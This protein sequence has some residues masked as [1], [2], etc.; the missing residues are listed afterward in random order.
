MPVIDVLPKNL[1]DAHFDKGSAVAN[2]ITI[3]NA[4]DWT[5]GI[6]ARIVTGS[7]GHIYLL[8]NGGDPLVDPVGDTGT[9]WIKS[10]AVS[11][12]DPHTIPEDKLFEMTN[13]SVANGAAG[14]FLEDDILNGLGV[15]PAFN[16]GRYL[17]FYFDK[18]VV[19]KAKCHL[20]NIVATDLDGNVVVPQ[21]IF[22]D[23]VDKTADFAAG[24]MV[25][26]KFVRV[27]F[28]DRITLAKLEWETPL[29]ESPYPWVISIG[30]DNAKSKNNFALIGDQRCGV[31]FSDGKAH[32]FE[33]T[34]LNREERSEPNLVAKIVTNNM[35]THQ[36]LPSRYIETSTM[37]GFKDTNVIEAGFTGSVNAALGYW[38]NNSAVGSEFTLK[39]IT[40]GAGSDL[41][42][43][44]IDVEL[45]PTELG[46]INTVLELWVMPVNGVL[47]PFVLV[48]LMNDDEHIDQKIGT[49][50]IYSFG[51]GMTRVFKRGIGKAHDW[52]FKIVSKTSKPVKIYAAGS[53]LM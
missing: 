17:W 37:T 7:D 24:N 4:P 3:K 30:N 47:N 45:D 29:G 44:A 49:R 14:V 35:L 42:A 23:N 19:T 51:L 28:E 25:E 8:A 18:D 39:G 2:K 41:F 31:H 26:M 9:N 10:G 43:G 22:A 50:L 6:P 1:H 40:K 16:Q 36:N 33:A 5:A 12:P 20:G 52:K 13:S 15:Q 21:A 38:S 32:S 27:E 46:Q 11:T 34:A 48:P 53:H